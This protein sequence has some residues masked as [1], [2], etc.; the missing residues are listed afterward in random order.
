MLPFRLLWIILGT[1]LLIGIG[2]GAY[3]SLETLAPGLQGDPAAK[4]ETY[5]A[6]THIHGTI[7]GFS[8][9]VAA[10]GGL[11]SFLLAERSIG[12]WARR[13]FHL[14]G[15]SI[16]IV[17]LAAIA[18]SA[19]LQT[20]IGSTQSITI[21]VAC[22]VLVGL[23]LLRHRSRNASAF[24]FLGACLLPALF[25][26]SSIYVLRQTDSMDLLADT[27]AA[28]AISHIIGL[29]FIMTVFSA[30]GV[31]AHARGGRL[32][33]WVSVAYIAA[34]VVAF[35]FYVSTQFSAGW[36]GMPRRYADYPESFAPIMQAA[37]WYSFAYA[38]IIL[39]GIA[40]FAF[41]IWTRDRSTVADV[42]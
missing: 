20:Y 13:A 11:T 3:M 10:T 41:A 37:S 24:I 35:R 23:L 42:F 27:Q 28:A 1:L 25:Y 26:A 38:A 34:L 15:F 17:A 16:I 8:L 31:W 32:N 33:G 39:I 2:A 18:V 22:A 9:P 19:A 7:M 6:A 36:A 14:C 4:A 40:R 30:L 12:G 5:R 29:A 21:A